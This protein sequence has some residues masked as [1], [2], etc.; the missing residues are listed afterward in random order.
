MPSASEIRKTQTI[1][2]VALLRRVGVAWLEANYS[3]DIRQGMTMAKLC[4]TVSG[5]SF[6]E[7]KENVDGPGMGRRGII[8]CA[9]AGVWF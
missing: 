2:K 6:E 9:W 8:A 3:E 1:D 7:D 4:S 5:W